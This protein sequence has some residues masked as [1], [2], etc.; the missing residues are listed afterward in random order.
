MACLYLVV[1]CF[2]EEEIIENTNYVIS[3]K[4]Q[5]L[6]EKGIINSNSKVLY[7]DDGSKDSTW[8]KI[9]KISQ[10]NKFV[11]AIR[12]ARNEGHQNALMAGM[13][14]AYDYADIVITIDA[15]LQ[16]DI[17]ALEEFILK[18]HSGKDIV[19]GIRNSRKTDGLIKKVTA[20][21]FYRLMKLLGTDTITNHADYRLMSHDA[22]TALFEYR[23]TQ[24][25]LRGIIASMG[26][27]TDVVKFDVQERKA[28]KSKYSMWKMIT[29]ALNGIT[30]L[31]IRPM[32]LVFYLGVT[33]LLISTGMI[34]YNIY[35]Y[36]QG[37][38][39]QGWASLL[40]SIWFLGGLTL[41]SIGIIGEYIG[42]TYMETKQRPLY[43]IKE[44]V[45]LNE[46]SRTSK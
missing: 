36:S 32:H 42:K 1:P 45:N 37:I 41:A 39:V 40:C 5:E 31:S 19:F 30:S 28:G 16:Q 22:L 29:L 23:E 26:F 34:I 6:I 46:Q 24:L 2:N 38:A 44:K 14:C 13:R 25:F 21:A 7:V 17:N 11:T 10:D 27:E 20:I 35:I 15:D 33:A 4:L 3:Q 12:L 8:K 9:Q 18:Y 43:F